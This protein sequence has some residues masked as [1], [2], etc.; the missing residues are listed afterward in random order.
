MQL[1]NFKIQS[2][3]TNSIFLYKGSMNR[4]RAPSSVIMMMKRLKLVQNALKMKQKKIP[5]VAFKGGLKFC[6]KR[7]GK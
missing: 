7:K 2:A 6:T 5:T 3:N 4:R 1:L